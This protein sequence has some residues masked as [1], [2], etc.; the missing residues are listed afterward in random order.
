M[1]STLGSLSVSPSTFAIGKPKCSLSHSSSSQ[2]AS[3]SAAIAAELGFRHRP[4]PVAGTVP[5]P[6]PSERQIGGNLDERKLHQHRK[7][8]VGPTNPPRLVLDRNRV[9][10][11]GG[12]SERGVQ[13]E[14]AARVR[15]KLLRQIR[16]EC[17][18]ATSE[19]RLTAARGNA[20]DGPPRLP[21]GP[22][23]G[24]GGAR[25]QQGRLPPRSRPSTRRWVGWALAIGTP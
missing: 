13:D 1:A 20:E 9:D 19:E 24:R 22:P 5:P 18:K 11:V 23:M 25:E 17:A 21:A 2:G 6:P 16:A 15:R 3:R 7:G 12:G 10:P 8:V 14:A 4:H